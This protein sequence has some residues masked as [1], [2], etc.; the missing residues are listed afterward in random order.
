MAVLRKL[1]HKHAHERPRTSNFELRTL[2]CFNL[3]TSN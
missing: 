3:L 2:I 1:Q